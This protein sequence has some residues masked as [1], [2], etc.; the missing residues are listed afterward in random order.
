MFSALSR[1]AMEQRSLRLRLVSSEADP[2]LPAIRTISDRM[3]AD[4]VAHE[5]LVVPGPHDY[6]WNRGPGGAEMILWHE[7]VQRG[8]APP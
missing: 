5:L 3:R 6:A 4:G 8:L 1:S 2:F 7:R